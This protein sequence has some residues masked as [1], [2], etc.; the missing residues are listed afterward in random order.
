MSVDVTVAADATAKSL[1]PAGYDPIDAGWGKHLFN[2]AAILQMLEKT[3]GLGTFRLELPSGDLYCSDLACRMFGLE[4][5]R[6]PVPLSAVF[7]AVVRGDKRDSAQQLKQAI[8]RKQGYRDI[9]HVS[10]A[11][12][13]STIE[14]HAD[15]ELNREGDIIA[16]VGTV[17]DI[18]E[19]AAVNAK[20]S[21]HS[22][23]M[24]ALLHNIPAAIAILDNEMRY[25]AVSDFWAAGH[26]M[27]APRDLVGKSHYEVHPELGEE[28]RREHRMV[29]EGHTL[30]RPRA[31]LTDRTGKPIAQTCVMC[32]WYT[33]DKKIGGMI[34]M[35]GTVDPEHKLPEEK[36]T[37]P[38]PTREEF[39]K[40]LA[41]L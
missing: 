40:I 1:L 7:G 25:L 20:S 8:A 3:V 15:A 30:R 38:L 19:R 32:P 36:S 24:R 17:R 13:V 10:V 37:S 26:G 23:V 27:K 12:R 14:C 35:L 5:T 39:L 11:G 31:F 4:P 6:E 9:L 29:L 28:I 2:A 16:I 18:S 22:L 41:S 33:T 34:I 21:S